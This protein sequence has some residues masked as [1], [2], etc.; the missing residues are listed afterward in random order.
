MKRINVLTLFVCVLFLSCTIG[1]TEE[2]TFLTPYIQE[3]NDINKYRWVVILPSTGCNG[4]IQHGEFFMK[5]NINRNDILFI[6]TKATSIKTMQLK[7]GINLRE[8]S[9]I[10]LDRE[11]KFDIPTKNSIYPCVI[12]LQKGSIKSI[13]FQNPHTDAFR[14]IRYK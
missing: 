10:Y 6:I 8:H 7:L 3:I 11:N 12:E 13:T 14:K 9:N 1:R 2:E 4:C 5:Q